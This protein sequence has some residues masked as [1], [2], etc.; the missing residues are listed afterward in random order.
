[1]VSLEDCCSGGMGVLG[2][3]CLSMVLDELGIGII[4][5]LGAGAAGLCN[6]KRK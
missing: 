4:G 3:I 6:S 2:N 5:V 1:M